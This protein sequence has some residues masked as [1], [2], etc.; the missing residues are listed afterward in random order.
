MR[1]NNSKF[2]IEAENKV[3]P[4]N[5]WKLRSGGIGPNCSQR[6]EILNAWEVRERLAYLSTNLSRAA[7]RE[8]SSRHEISID[9]DYLYKLGM[10]QNWKCSLT[11]DDLEFSRGGDFLNKSN[12]YSCTIDRIN[13]DFGYIKGNVQLV[14]WKINYIKQHL[15]KKEFL[16][17]CKKVV[18]QCL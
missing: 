10:R 8:K 2:L 17:I 9:I 3:W 7:C 11:G 5:K 1:V 18:E 4:E 6:S 15:S 14:T 13:S 16:S 12:P